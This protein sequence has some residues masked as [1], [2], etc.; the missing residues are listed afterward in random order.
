[1]AADAMLRVLLVGQVEAGIRIGLDRL[2]ERRAVDLRESSPEDVD[3]AVEIWTPDILLVALAVGV[4]GGPASLRQWRH[5][6]PDADARR[7]SPPDGARLFPLEGV[8]T[9]TQARLDDLWTQVKQ[10][11]TRAR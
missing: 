4:A 10:G 1:M 6:L 5:L 11:A 7:L 8:T 3:R 2:N 9:E